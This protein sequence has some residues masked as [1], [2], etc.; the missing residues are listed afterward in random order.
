[1]MWIAVASLAVVGLASAASAVAGWCETGGVG[2]T[3]YTAYATTPPPLALRVMEVSAAVETVAVPV[4]ALSSAAY[5]LLL[6]R[7]VRRGFGTRGFEVRPP[8]SESV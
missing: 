1:M 6:D 5:I 8:G 4:A 2:W 7:E 3:F